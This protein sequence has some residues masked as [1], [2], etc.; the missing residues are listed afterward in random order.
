MISANHTNNAYYAELSSDGRSF[1]FFS[2]ASNL[3][4]GDANETSDVLLVLVTQSLD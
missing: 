3:V 1:A 4:S 2:Y